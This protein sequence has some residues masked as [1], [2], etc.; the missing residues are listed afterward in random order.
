MIK[1]GQ[2]I[3]YDEHTH[4][5]TIRYIRPDA[6][7]KCGACGSLN[8]SGE[9]TLKAEC[10]V[11]NWV[12]VVLPDEKFVSAS[13][14]AYALPLVGLIVGLLAGYFLSGKN[15]LVSAA[16]A[17]LGIGAA[18]LIQRL[19]EKKRGGR[20]EWQP[21]VDAVYLGKPDELM[22]GCKGSMS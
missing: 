6:C 15:E 16:G 20:A 10:A 14:L 12:R 21:R 11:G 7:A 3:A 2:V 8:Q 18:L 1:F 22:I 4:N 5:A 19:H 13:L 17:I 9:I